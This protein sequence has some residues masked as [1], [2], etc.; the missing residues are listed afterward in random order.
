MGRP[1]NTVERRAQIV[2]GLRSVMAERGYERASVVA[3][4]KAA[5]LSPGLVHY[6]FGSKQEILVALVERLAQAVDERFDRLAT[7]AGDDAAKRLDAWIDAALA[8][9][10]DTDPEWVSA[11]VFVGAEALRQQEVRLVYQQAIERRLAQLRVV[12]DGA[13]RQAGRSTRNARK[14]AAIVLSAVEGAYQLGSAAAEVMPTGFAAP[15]L[16]RAVRGLIDGEPPT[17]DSSR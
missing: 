6:H 11:W 9:G 12:L 5:G 7:S 17:R 10:P 4:A 13:L 16:R 2:A 3:I 1:S 14:L 8:L 15:G